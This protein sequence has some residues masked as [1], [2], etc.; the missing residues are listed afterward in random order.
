[1]Q[2]AHDIGDV[3]GRNPDLGRVCALANGIGQLIAKGSLEASF[4]PGIR[5]DAPEKN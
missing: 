4:E 5:F 2:P 3:L 1:M